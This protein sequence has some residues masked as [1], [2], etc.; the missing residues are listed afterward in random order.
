MVSLKCVAVEARLLLFHPDKDGGFNGLPGAFH[1]IITF[2]L[3]VSLGYTLCD[4]TFNLLKL[5]SDC[6]VIKGYKV[7][8]LVSNWKCNSVACKLLTR[9][10][11]VVFVAK[12]STLKNL[13]LLKVR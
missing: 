7:V 10:K 1:H 8:L 11:M 4:L 9:S 12:L 13:Y 6:S 3:M 2:S 5:L